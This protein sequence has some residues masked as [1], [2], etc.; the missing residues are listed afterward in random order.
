MPDLSYSVPERGI[1]RKLVDMGTN[2]FAE[3]T[4]A[5]DPGLLQAV[6]S[7]TLTRQAN[8][9]AYSAGQL[10]G[11]SASTGFA[12]NGFTFSGFARAGAAAGVTAGR[13]RLDRARLYKSQANLLGSFELRVFRAQP[14]IT[15]ADAGSFSAGVPIGA[16]GANARLVA[17]FA[18]DFTTAVQ[19]SDGSELAATTISGIPA[20]VGLP[21]GATDLFGLLI[22]T[23]NYTPASGETFSVVLEGLAV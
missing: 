2:T 18:F 4:V 20:V 22:A 7:N 8:T 19:G 5:R 16:G 13:V 6:V 15:I 11:G 12:N 1:S 10:I 17:R 3:E 23:G 21:N 9:T 14:T